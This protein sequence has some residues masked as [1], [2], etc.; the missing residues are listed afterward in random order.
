[1]SKQKRVYLV[2]LIVFAIV[3]VALLFGKRNST[4]ESKDPKLETIDVAATKKIALFEDEAGFSFEYYKDLT[5]TD[6]TPDDDTHYSLLSIANKDDQE[7]IQIKLT[8]TKYKKLANWLKNREKESSA[9]ANLTGA[10]AL[11]IISANNYRTDNKL[12][13]AAIDQGVLYLIE[14]TDK[15]AETE[16]LYKLITNSVKLALPGPTTS[17]PGGGGGSNIIYEAE[18]V[19]E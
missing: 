5:V 8:D 9:T 6:I 3:I 16:E 4:K 12:F 13:T 18:E 17:T 2:F 19:I 11:D 7:L 1:M 10:T 15:E 14:T